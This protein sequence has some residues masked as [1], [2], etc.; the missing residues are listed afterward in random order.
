MALPSKIG[1]TTGSG[2]S[3]SINEPLQVPGRG[4]LQD[5]DRQPPQKTRSI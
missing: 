1:T 5:R 4:R 3:A 2:R